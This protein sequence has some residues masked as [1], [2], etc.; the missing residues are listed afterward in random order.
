MLVS[1]VL[2][3][4]K[5]SEA[6]QKL[7]ILTEEFSCNPKVNVGLK[8]CLIILLHISMLVKHNNRMLFAQDY[9]NLTVND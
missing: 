4:C 5:Q 2:L 6:L 3:W 1:S 8:F 7:F 9:K